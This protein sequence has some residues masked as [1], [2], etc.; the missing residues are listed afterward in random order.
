MNSFAQKQDS[1]PYRELLDYPDSYTAGSMASR[2]IDGLGFRFY[3]ATE[4]LREEDLAFRP[5]EGSR[6]TDETIDH[7]L[8]MSN[9]IVNSLQKVSNSQAADLSF[10]EKRAF[11][12]NNLKTASDILLKSSAKD[13]NTYT[14]QLGNGETL[15]FWNFVNGQISDC[16]WHRGQISS[17]RRM[18]GNPFN[19]KVN[20]FRGEVRD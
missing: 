1:L 17:F 19:P 6:N 5:N 2:M 13:L 10:D 9:R 14:I 4:G 8:S 3:W 11:V 16:I 20:L 12:L 7:I 15:P 18:S